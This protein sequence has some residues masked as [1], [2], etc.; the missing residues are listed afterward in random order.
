MNSLGINKSKKDNLAEYYF[1]E[2]FS[3]RDKLTKYRPAASSYIKA[4]LNRQH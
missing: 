2:K 4:L 3:L 1:I